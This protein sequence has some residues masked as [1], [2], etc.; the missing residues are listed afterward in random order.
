MEG[1]KQV[2]GYWRDHRNWSSG[3]SAR[4]VPYSVE[5][6]IS[7]R[8]EFSDAERFERRSVQAGNALQQNRA[9]AWQGPWNH[10]GGSGARDNRTVGDRSLQADIPFVRAVE[11]V[12]YFHRLREAILSCMGK[13][14]GEVSENVSLDKVYID[15]PYDTIYL[16]QWGYVDQKPMNDNAN[17]E[18]RARHR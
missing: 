10:L 5:E 18:S 17:Y 6:Y 9:H 8:S 12:G 15:R 7:K 1:N 2:P 4:P 13:E 11:E 16:V 3:G 14:A